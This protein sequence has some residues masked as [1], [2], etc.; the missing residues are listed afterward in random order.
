MESMKHCP[1]CGNPIISGYHIVADVG[2][3]RYVFCPEKRTA[4]VGTRIDE[5][6]AKHLVKDS[7][8]KHMEQKGA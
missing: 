3:V 1:Y 4:N 7:F 2:S 5:S 6:L 8:F